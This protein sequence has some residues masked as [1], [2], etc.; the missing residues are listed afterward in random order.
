MNPVETKPLLAAKEAHWLVVGCPVEKP[1]WLYCLKLPWVPMDT[2][3]ENHQ[4]IGV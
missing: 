3:F 4:A 1:G 2:R